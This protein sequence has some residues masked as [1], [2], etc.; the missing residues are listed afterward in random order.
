MFQKTGTI[1]FALALLSFSFQKDKP[2]YKIFTKSAKSSNYSSLMKELAAADIVLFG[3]MH[4]N[5]VNHWLQLEVLKELFAAKGTNLVLGAEM[6]E[7]DNQNA[8]DSFLSGLYSDKEFARAAR[9]WPNYKTDY[10]PLVVFARENKIPFVATNIPRRYASLVFK[11]GFSALDTLS[12]LEKS[13]MAPLPMM[14][15]STLPGYRDILKATGG[16]GGPTLSMAQAS[17]DATMGYFIK[18]N[19][20]PGKLFLH[21]N[22]TYHSNN[23]EGISWYLKQYNSQIKI[24]TI[25]SVEQKQI[26]KLEKEHIGIANYII[27]TPETLTKTH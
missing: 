15:D 22:G 11:K 3:E 24:V 14:F 16:H 9:L 7:A 5:P 27:A 13:W 18:E 21:F 23:F 19:Y 2:A 6:F 25:A 8:L 20:K 4:D 10:K 12:E 1:L 17:K 26:R